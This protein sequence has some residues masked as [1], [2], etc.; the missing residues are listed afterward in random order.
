MPL[1]HPI[2]D[3]LPL[4]HHR[5]ACYILSYRLPTCMQVSLQ[6]SR[7]EHLTKYNQVE[8]ISSPQCGNTP[9]MPPYFRSHCPTTNWEL[10]SD[11]KS[12]QKPASF[13]LHFGSSLPAQ[14]CLPVYVCAFR[15]F[16]Q[17]GDA[18]RQPLKSMGQNG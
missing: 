4:C 12:H 11:I 3:Q 10:F 5:I 14:V 13:I 15:S 6:Q 2:C 1:I 16:L 8:R 7:G 18:H 9:M 17:Y